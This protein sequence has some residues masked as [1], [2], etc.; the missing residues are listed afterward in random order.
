MVIFCGDQFEGNYEPPELGDYS[1]EAGID[2]TYDNPYDEI[3]DITNVYLPGVEV[4]FIRGNN[5]YDTGN[6]Y[7]QYAG[8]GPLPIQHF[9]LVKTKYV[10][11]FRFGAPNGDDPDFNYSND[12]I[13]ALNDYLANRSDKSKLVLVAGHYPIDDGINTPTNSQSHLDINDRT[14]RN[15]GNAT[16]VSAILEMY[17]QPVLFLWSHN[18]DNGP[19]LEEH[20][21]KTYGTGY[22]TM[23]SGAVG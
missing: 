18:H 4:V 7:D 11:V 22:Y 1:S 10:D 3:R 13:A 19:V 9:G 6:N 20:I 15:A 8:F 16:S 2:T 21:L 17:D 14:F 5:D 23:N 12:Q